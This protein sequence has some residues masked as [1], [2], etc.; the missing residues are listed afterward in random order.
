MYGI[1]IDT[2]PDGPLESYGAGLCPI[3]SGI[4]RCPGTNFAQCQGVNGLKLCPA[5]NYGGVRDFAVYL[6]GKS[7][8]V[9]IEIGL[10]GNGQVAR[11]IL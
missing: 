9:A 11:T 4:E 8:P 1:V 2:D 3:V 5:T 10:A 7:T 6:P